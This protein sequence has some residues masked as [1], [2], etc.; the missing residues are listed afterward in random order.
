MPAE[1]SRPLVSERDRELALLG[2]ADPK[3]LVDSLIARADS[4]EKKTRRLEDFV[5]SKNYRAGQPL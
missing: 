3:T 5:T 2:R 1:P 4:I